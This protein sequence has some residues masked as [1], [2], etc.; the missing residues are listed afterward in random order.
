[1]VGIA[2]AAVTALTVS[3]NNDYRRTRLEADEAQ[4]RQLLLAGMFS[5][6]DKPQVLDAP[7]PARGWELALPAEMT[8]FANGVKR[9]SIRIM[10]SEDPSSRAMKIDAA[11]GRR[12]MTQQVVLQKHANG[13][14][15][16]D[17]SLLP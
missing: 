3:I 15:M 5:V 2:G 4:A 12:R 16:L 10:P 11:F 1:M 7:P 9:L 8:P 14:H 17:A 6:G 13:W